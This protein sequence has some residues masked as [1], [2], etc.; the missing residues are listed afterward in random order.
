MNEIDRPRILD[1]VIVH[2]PG[3]ARYVH[4]IYSCEPWLITG[5]RPIQSLQGNHEGYPLGMY[6]L[7]LAL[8]PLID[9]LQ[10]KCKFDFNF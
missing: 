4:M 7:P 6:M 10:E 1:E 3:I 2:A 8:E 5:V 9:Y